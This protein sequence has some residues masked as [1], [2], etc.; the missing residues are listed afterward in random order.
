LD[1]LT[2]IA[3]LV[4][5]VLIIRSYVL[6]PQGKK[7][8]VP[9]PAEAIAFSAALTRGVQAASVGI[10]EFSDL[11][12]PYCGRFARDTLPAIDS[13]YLEPGRV[14]LA[15]VNLPLAQIHP[16]AARAAEAI[17]CAG[18]QGKFWGAHDRMYHDQQHLALADLVNLGAALELGKAYETC[19]SSGQAAGR[20]QQDVAEAHKLGITT[21][22]TFLVG[23]LQS[24]GRLKVQQVIV[25]AQPFKTFQVALDALLAPPRRFSAMTSPIFIASALVVVGIVG[26]VLVRKRRSR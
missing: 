7:T 1:V 9:V 13:A 24:D 15:F 5:A 8:T 2:S 25:G 4:A 14:L 17:V 22:P 19:L 6:A 16:F 3:A 11:Q 26:V 21:T 18:D 12:C 20:V 23:T 10:L